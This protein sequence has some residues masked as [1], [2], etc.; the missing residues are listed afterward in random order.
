[1]TNKCG[2]IISN[3]ST[4]PNTSITTKIKNDDNLISVPKIV[5]VNG[6]SIQ[7]SSICVCY[8]GWKDNN[9]SPNT[10]SINVV[11]K[12]NGIIEGFKNVSNSSSSNVSHTNSDSINNDLLYNST[13]LDLN[14]AGDLPLV[15]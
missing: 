14:S 11:Q 15:I 2:P 4:F 5:C 9:F 7:D 13:T 1:L 3:Y 10:N 8:P 12:C 6:I